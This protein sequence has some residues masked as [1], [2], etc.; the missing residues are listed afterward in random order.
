MGRECPAAVPGG[1]RTAR[2]GPV[3]SG[4]PRLRGGQ[5]G[6]VRVGAFCWTAQLAGWPESDANRAKGP[7]S[8]APTKAGGFRDVGGLGLRPGAGSG[9]AAAGSLPPFS[10]PWQLRQD[11]RSLPLTASWGWRGSAQGPGGTVGRLAHDQEAGLGLSWGEAAMARWRR[12]I[13]QAHWSGQSASHSSLTPARCQI[14]GREAQERMGTALTYTG[15]PVLRNL[16]AQGQTDGPSFKEEAKELI[17]ILD[18][19]CDGNKAGRR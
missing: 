15:L 10:R 4:F 6:A 2:C 14:P 5:K 13:W 9:E 17:L 18:K 11:M 1:R 19:C 16:G 12:V 8:A 3:A 7:G